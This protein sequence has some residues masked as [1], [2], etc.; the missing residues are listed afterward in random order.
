MKRDLIRIFIDEIYNKTPEKNYETNNIFYNEIDGIWSIDLADLIDYKTSNKN[1]FRYIL[2]IIDNF[3]KYTWAI[4]LKNKIS[5]TINEISKIIITSKRRPN[6]LEGNRSMEFYN[7]F[8]Q[9]LL[10]AKNIQNYS[11]FASK[12][13]SLAERAFGTMWFY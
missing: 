1:R 11:R 9:K 7:N 4:P 12:G 13:P 6:K 10:K 5:P 8:S 2:T 3:S